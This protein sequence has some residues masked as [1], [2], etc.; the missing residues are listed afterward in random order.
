[1]SFLEGGQTVV[2]LYTDKPNKYEFSIF[3]KTLI[4]KRDEYLKSKYL[5]LSPSLDYGTQLENLIALD[6]LGVISNEK[7][8]EKRQELD[9]MYKNF[10]Y[11]L[12]SN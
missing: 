8:I 9:E 11:R 2:N 12:D 3:I 5:N 10:P 1:M 6:N 7:F 4:T